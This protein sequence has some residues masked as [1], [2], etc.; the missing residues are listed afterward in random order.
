[1]NKLEFITLVSQK[2]KLIRIE[3]GYSQEKMADILSISKK[4]LV[5]VEKG[6]IT[7]NFGNAVAVAVIFEDSEMIG[8]VLGGDVTDSIKSL[9]LEHYE[10][11]PQTMGG[12]VWWKDLDITADYK[13]QQNMI[14]QHFRILTGDDRRICSSFNETFIKNRF[15]ELTGLTVSPDKKEAGYGKEIG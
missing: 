8:M 1:M 10:N 9:A 15:R 12:K 7:L 2:L 11:R 5:E 14:S 13:I 4:T 6:R 3:N